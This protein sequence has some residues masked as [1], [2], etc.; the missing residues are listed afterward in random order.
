MKTKSVKVLSFE[1][2]LK[3]LPGASILRKNSGKRISLLS[4]ARHCCGGFH[5][6]MTLAKV[7]RHFNVKINYFSLKM[8]FYNHLKLKDNNDKS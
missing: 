8:Y 2:R 4:L 5:S 6:E 7:P 1:D 3:Y